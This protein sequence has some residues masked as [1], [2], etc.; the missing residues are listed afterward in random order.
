MV[1]I[2]GA[3]SSGIV[4]AKVL[5]EHSINFGYFEKGSGIGSNWRY[6]NNN[7]MSSTSTYALLRINWYSKAKA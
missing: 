5:K 1:C 3:G 2:V 7:G 6:M 4:A